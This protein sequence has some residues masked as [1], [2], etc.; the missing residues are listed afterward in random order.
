MRPGDESMPDLKDIKG[1]ETAK[2][3]LEVALAHL[4][5]LFLDMPEFNPQVLDARRQPLENGETVIA[6]AN[7]RIA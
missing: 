1:Q 2:R 5:L 6:R 4:S 7:H 3:A